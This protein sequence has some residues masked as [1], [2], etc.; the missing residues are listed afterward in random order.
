MSTAAPRLLVLAEPEPLF[1]PDLVARIAE[2]HPPVAILEVA[3]R[4]PAVAFKRLFATFGAL[5]GAA[6]LASAGLAAILDRLSPGRYYSLA[7]VARRLDVPYERVGDLH[8]EDCIAALERHAPDVVFTQVSRLVRSELLA[9]G[10]FWNKHCSLLPSYAGVY[11]TFWAMRDARPELG[12]T[13]HVMDEVFDG[14]RVL[15]QAAIP[16]AGHSFFS[17]YHALYD[18]SADLVTHALAHEESP[19]DVRRGDLAASYFSFPGRDD[20]RAFRRAG[21]RFGWPFRLHPRVELSRP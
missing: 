17:A 15:G 13:L 5:T 3:G 14:G 4:R 7:K 1:L 6:I 12:V 20:R 11:P 16:S 18:L 9:R 21:G 8:G 10:T 2:R 19:P